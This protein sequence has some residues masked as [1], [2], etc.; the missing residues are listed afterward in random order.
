VSRLHD[1]RGNLMENALTVWRADGTRELEC[2]GGEHTA[3]EV[4]T[5]QTATRMLAGTIHQQRGEWMA[6]RD[7]KLG[8]MNS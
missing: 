7:C 6:H 2:W 4:S 1:T 3:G 5:W 8:T